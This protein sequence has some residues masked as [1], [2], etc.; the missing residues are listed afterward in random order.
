M[1]ENKFRVWCEWE[2]DGKIEKKMI[3]IDD[4]SC[5][6]L[7][8]TGELMFYV[9]GVRPYIVDEDYKKIIPLFYSGYQ[10][11]ENSKIFE[12]HILKIEGHINHVVGFEGGMFCWVNVMPCIPIKEKLE[13][14]KCK[15]I[16][17]I[18]ENPELENKYGTKG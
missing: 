15:I 14:Y 9:V 11:S 2:V 10:D 1:K 17:T 6:L 13:K 5:F 4:E 16:G 7:T 3:D 8:Q 12:G 18:Y